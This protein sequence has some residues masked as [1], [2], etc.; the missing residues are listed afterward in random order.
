VA[1]EVQVD[2]PKSLRAASERARRKALLI[3]PHIAPLTA[4]VARLRLCKG[5]AYQIPDFD[6]LDGGMGARVLV[7][8]EAPGPKAVETGFISRNNPDRTAKNVFDLFRDA[9][10]A[11][12][13]TV[14]WNVIPWYIGTSGQIRSGT[15]SDLVEARPHT[16]ELI[17]LLFQLEVVVLIGR[18]ASE[19]FRAL[20]LETT[21]RTLETLH[22]SPKVF[23]TRKT[24][25]D[26]ISKTLIE[27]KGIVLGNLHNR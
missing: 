4:Y 11:R 21:A 18:K 24:A 20:A 8:L 12:T 3:D 1:V 23:A 5:P 22:P 25:R 13:E 27:V 17:Q 7:L 16:Q 10:I 19:A 26:E 15:R 2:Q 14:L 9:E 6:P